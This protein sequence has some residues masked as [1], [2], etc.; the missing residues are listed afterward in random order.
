MGSKANIVSVFSFVLLLHKRRRL[1]NIA[2]VVAYYIQWLLTT[3][4]ARGFLPT[5]VQS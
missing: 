5:D 4:K 3:V 2:G 1:F